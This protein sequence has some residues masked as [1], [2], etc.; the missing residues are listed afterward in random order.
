MGLE[1]GKVLLAKLPSPALRA[2]VVL[3]VLQ[4]HLYL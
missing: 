4:G 3:L 2:N 1:I